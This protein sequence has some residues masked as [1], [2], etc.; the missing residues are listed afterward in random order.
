MFGLSAE[1]CAVV[2]VRESRD[3]F[4][5][6]IRA[7]LRKTFGLTGKETSIA[8]ALVG[9]LSL[10]EIAI[11]ENISFSVAQLHLDRIFR[12]TDARLQSQLVARLSSIGVLQDCLADNVAPEHLAPL[13]RT[14]PNM[15][16]RGLV[17]ASVG[18]K[19]ARNTVEAMA[20]IGLPAAV[21]SANGS[22]KAT[23]PLFDRETTL[24]VATVSGGV[25]IAEPESNRLFQMALQA[26]GGEAVLRSIPL[27]NALPSP[28]VV[29]V[30]PLK[31]D[32]HE[33]LERSDL[34]IVATVIGASTLVPSP[35]ILTALFDLTRAEVQLATALAQGLNLK[36]AAA[37]AGLKFSTVRTY[38]N[39]IFRK[40]GTNQ[41]SQLVALL[42][43][44]HSFQR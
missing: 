3:A 8:L 10:K 5:P 36:D 44:A 16:Q 14:R 22:V 41:Q 24:F 13:D 33:P 39:R 27:H 40:T 42:K 32:A 38:L 31:R 35:T 2:L 21:L 43:S 11:C 15:A 25:A 20:V 34:L 9:G 1:P 12:K 23:N 17:A 26:G 4:S 18:L 7:Q 28:V 30:L 29:H 6:P 19:R 37:E